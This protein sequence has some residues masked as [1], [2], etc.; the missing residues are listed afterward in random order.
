MIIIFIALE[1]LGSDLIIMFILLE[2]LDQIE[3]IDYILKYPIP[4]IL[5]LSNTSLII[6]F[7]VLDI[8]GSN[9]MT[10]IIIIIIIT[11]IFLTF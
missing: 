6:I 1:H 2:H 8:K 7:V 11:F 9:R 5:K 10:I 3:S 4:W